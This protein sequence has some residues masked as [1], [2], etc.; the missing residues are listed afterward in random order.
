MGAMVVLVIYAIIK[1]MVNVEDI[2]RRDYVLILIS[3]GLD[4]VSCFYVSKEYTLNK[5]FA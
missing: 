3:G 4:C 2:V 1:V 5:L